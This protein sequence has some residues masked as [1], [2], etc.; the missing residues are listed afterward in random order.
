MTI[1]EIRAAADK[2]RICA[3]DNEAAHA[4]E[5]SLMRDFIEWV[6]DGNSTMEELRAM[7][8]IVRTTGDLKFVRWYA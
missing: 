7:A 6:R 3:G 1:E 8:A 5:D 4:Y 2:V